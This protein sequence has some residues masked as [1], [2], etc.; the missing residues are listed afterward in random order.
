[1]NTASALR[2]ARIS[3]EYTPRSARKS[4]AKRSVASRIA[5]T[6]PAAR[7]PRERSPNFE[8][9]GSITNVTSFLELNRFAQTPS[10]GSGSSM[11]KLQLRYRFCSGVRVRLREFRLQATAIQTVLRLEKNMFWT[12]NF[13]M[14]PPPRSISEKT[15]SHMK[16][17]R[18]TSLLAHI[19]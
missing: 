12:L 3:R 9:A 10:A 7:G 16:K 11:E 2:V 18:K 15:M 8:I 5:R 14:K 19:I 6:S 13:K 1:M 4:P 17:I